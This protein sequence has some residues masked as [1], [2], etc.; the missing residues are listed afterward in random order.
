MISCDDGHLRVMASSLLCSLHA[1]AYPFYRS[2]SLYRARP[3]A[4]ALQGRGRWRSGSQRPPPW[5]LRQR[6]SLQV[7][8]V[9]QG[10][11]PRAFRLLL[12]LRAHGCSASASYPS[13]DQQNILPFSSPTRSLVWF[14]DTARAVTAE[15]VLLGFPVRATLTSSS[16]QRARFFSHL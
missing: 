11:R 14:L 8:F 15:L 1:H 10:Q 6:K 9:R 7:S 12:P 16:L 13:A 4:I 3:E 2:A 5:G